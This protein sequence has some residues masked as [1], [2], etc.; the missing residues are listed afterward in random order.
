MMWYWLSTIQQKYL[1][2]PTLS[3]LIKQTKLQLPSGPCPG[4]QKKSSHFNNWCSISR[5]NSEA[6]TT[7]NSG[8]ADTPQN[9]KLQK[10]KNSGVTRLTITKNSRNSKKQNQ[11]QIN[12]WKDELV[13]SEWQTL[14][15]NY[16]LKLLRD[17]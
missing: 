16:I 2:S 17:C 15:K 3:E 9:K 6:I 10:I 5:N 11:P 14:L 7:Q 4:R 1:L 12:V 13:G 8:E